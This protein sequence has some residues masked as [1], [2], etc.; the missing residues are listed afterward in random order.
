MTKS[1]LIALGGN[2]LL[3]AGEKGTDKEQLSHVRETAACCLKIIQDGYRLILTHGNGPQVGAILLKNEIAKDTLPPMPL[4][5]CGAESQG[6]IGYMIQREFY[7]V[8]EISKI[9]KPVA[10]ILTQVLVNSHDPAFANPTKPI[11]PFYKEEES[12]VLEKKQG[13]TMV[14][15]QGKGFRRVV[16]SPIPI[17]IVE[18]EVIKDLI[19]NDVI[20]IACGGGGIPVIRESN[21]TL[22]GVEAVIDKDRTA[23]VLG[24][25]LGVDILMILTDVDKIAINF[26]KKDQKFLDKI[27]VAEAKKYIAEGHF[28]KGSMEPKVQAACHFVENG[29]KKAIITSLNKSKMA[30]DGLTGTIITL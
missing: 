1:I 14:Y 16:P 30:L 7:N 28:G 27:T 3:Q 12:K 4:D 5:I 20:V 26:G 13:W 18:K 25:N 6:L 15:Q 29:G 8:L 9:S 17:T 24:N 10:C 11:G 19:E 2:A 23:A 22:T 21:G